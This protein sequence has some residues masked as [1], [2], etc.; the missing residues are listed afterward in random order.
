MKTKRMVFSR[1]PHLLP[2]RQEWALVGKMALRS[3]ILVP[4]SP[5]NAAQSTIIARM[6]LS[7]SPRTTPSPSSA[8]PSPSAFVP[9]GHAAV[10][11]QATNGTSNVINSFLAA[12]PRRSPDHDKSKVNDFQCPG[13]PLASGDKQAAAPTA[14]PTKQPKKRKKLFKSATIVL[15]SDEPDSALAD[16]SGFAIDI[17]HAGKSHSVVHPMRGL[18]SC[19]QEGWLSVLD[20]PGIRQKPSTST[21]FAAS[22]V[23]PAA[24]GTCERRL[25][26]AD[27]EVG[28]LQTSAV[29][30]TTLLSGFAYTD[31]TTVLHTACDGEVATKRRKIELAEASTISKVTTKPRKRVAEP[32][33]LPPKP[34]KKAKSPKKKPQ[35]ITALA[36]APYQPA[37]AP[38]P[39]NPTVSEYFASRTT[40]TA[41]CS[42]HPKP[43]AVLEKPKRVRKSRAKPLDAMACHPKP[44]KPTK[45]RKVKLKFNAADHVP[46]LYSPERAC[47]QIGQQD[48]LFGTSSQMAVDEAPAV[49]RD[50]QAAMM[51]S[52]D[53]YSAFDDSSNRRTSA[54]AMIAPDKISVLVDHENEKL[55]RAASRDFKGG[56]LRDDSGLVK[57][58]VRVRTV[59]PP[60]SNAI[61]I[62]PVVQVPGSTRHLSPELT[63]MAL[64]ECPLAKTTVEA[65][66]VE[67]NT[68]P[69]S[70]PKAHDDS[71]LVLSSS[72]PALR[73]VVQQPATTGS[74]LTLP[75]RSSQEVHLLSSSP[76]RADI[77]NP[78]VSPHRNVLQTVDANIRM[79]GAVRGD[80]ASRLKQARQMTTK[81]KAGCSGK[82]PVGRPRKAD[83]TTV[84]GIPTTMGPVKRRPGRPRKIA[85]TAT[86]ADIPSHQPSKTNIPV[87]LGT[88]HSASQPIRKA[89]DWANIDEISDDD[90]PQ[91]P[92][93]PRI[94]S[95][96]TPPT[97]KPLEL[98]PVASPTPSLRTVS[99]IQQASKKT[100]AS[101]KLAD[102][103]WSSIFPTLF[104]RITTAVKSAP[105]STDPKKPD[106]LQKILLYDPIVLEDL[107]AWLNTQQVTVE[108]KRAVKKIAVPK[109]RKN[110]T[111][112]APQVGPFAAPAPEFETVSEPLRP[113][114]V[115]KWCEDKSICCLWREG[116]RGGVKAKY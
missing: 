94:R 77:A 113:W 5:P 42:Q 101:V 80:V 62:E 20:E 27:G 26:G 100:F 32:E 115:Q 89:E 67:A 105:R 60:R 17:V 9:S 33:M 104:P 55:W 74:L 31:H 98:S 68:V 108:V 86:D 24:E 75:F 103:Q 63:T 53:A 6:T 21:Y 19:A 76:P 96:F 66:T 34:T 50:I 70:S 36:M 38:D 116:L 109:K 45:I 82:R 84:V 49:I 57:R 106:W 51:H 39:E 71:W 81:A 35:T 37:K 102:E 78:A 93:P 73:E 107:T 111:D 114:M 30:L 112:A 88:G 52:E 95:S 58:K 47:R 64:D 72:S 99:V 7:S 3:S 10:D 18:W 59:L 28:G 14:I 1:C 29:P 2:F 11:A 13:M 15:N 91:T 54:Q 25:S 92:S 110:K 4:S 97:V 23:T 41:E 8:L 44:K 87:A 56:I 65:T 85:A 83:S 16:Q 12:V 46:K 69:P 40:P 90:V 79:P 43:D 48:F 22:E 61:D